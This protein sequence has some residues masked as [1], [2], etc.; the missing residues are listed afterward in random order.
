[1]S[2]ILT[3]HVGSLPRSK[4][5]SEILFSKDRGEKFIKEDFN[6]ILKKKW[7]LISQKIDTH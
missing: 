6:N 3:T 5:L 1:M 2:K 7:Y 4:G